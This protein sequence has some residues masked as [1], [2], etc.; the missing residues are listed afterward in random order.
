MSMPTDLVLTCVGMMVERPDVISYVLTK[1]NGR[2]LYESLYRCIR[3]DVMSGTLLPGQAMPSKREFA[4]RLGVSPVTVEHAYRE[5]VAEGYL[6]ALP[7]KGHFVREMPS[8]RAPSD[9]RVETEG[10]PCGFA[11]SGQRETSTGLGRVEGGPFGFADHALRPR[12]DL[13]SSGSAFGSFP[14]KTWARIVRDV[15]LDDEAA[16]LDPLP[17]QGSLRLRKAICAHVRLSRGIE[18]DPDQVVVGSGAQS[19]YGLLSLMFG[20]DC[21]GVAVENPGYPTVQATYQAHGLPVFAVSVD[22]EGLSVEELRTTRASVVHV[23]PSHQYPTGVLMPISRRY[24]LLSW[25][26]E[27]SGRCIV[28]DDYDCEFRLSGRP[29]PSLASVDVEGSVVYMNTFSKS[30]LGS[31]RIAYMIVP[32][33]LLGRYRSACGFV[34][35]S[36]SALEQETLARFMERGEFDRQ[37]GRTCRRLRQCKEAILSSLKDRIAQ[38]SV[39]VENAENGM[40]FLLRLPSTVDEKT[41]SETLLRHGVRAALVSDCRLETAQGSRPTVECDRF[42]WGG[43]VVVNYGALSVEDASEL[44]VALAN[45]LSEMGEKASS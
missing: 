11:P 34:P 28:E 35:C 40:F 3:D 29:V 13:A 24:E 30:L 18:A 43:H 15:L 45:A 22:D 27:S 21:A 25:A 23:A 42:G 31:M 7:R 41:A 39:G 19:L 2:P 38:G 33:R 9:S 10:G 44:G 14:S 37:A 5:L 12:F 32:K 4:D 1:E 16:L 36:V 6:E 26:S 17:R 20:K 8:L